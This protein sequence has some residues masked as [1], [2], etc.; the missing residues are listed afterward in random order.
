MR[1]QGNSRTTLKGIPECP[2][3][4]CQI[5]WT[6]IIQLLAFAVQ[7]C[8]NDFMSKAS[9]ADLEQAVEYTHKITPNSVS[10][11]LKISMISQTKL[12]FIVTRYKALFHWRNNN[13]LPFLPI[14]WG[15]IL[16]PLIEYYCATIVKFSS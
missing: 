10:I 12:I 9:G 5:W 4:M 14:I 16:Q 2:R 1:W 6:K 8:S 11:I 7:I 15:H 3:I 13:A